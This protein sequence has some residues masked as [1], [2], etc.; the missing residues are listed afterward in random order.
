MSVEKWLLQFD[1]A[2][3]CIFGLEIDEVFVNGGNELP[4]L[5]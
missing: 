3:L 1:E 2:A 4:K 5:E